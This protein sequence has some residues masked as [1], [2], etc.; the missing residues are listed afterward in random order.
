M[1]HVSFYLP[2]LILPQC[3]T[4]LGEK[5]SGSSIKNHSNGHDRIGRLVA[6][7]EVEHICT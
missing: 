6:S 3:L 7:P 5:L 2:L 1:R 4:S